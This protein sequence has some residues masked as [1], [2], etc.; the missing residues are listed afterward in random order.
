MLPKFFFSCHTPYF[1]AIF[2]SV[3]ARSEKF[4]FCLPMNFVC[5]A[6][7]SGE[8]PRIDVLIFVKSGRSSR[9]LHA[10]IVQ[11][12]VESFG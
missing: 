3:S 5:E 1:V 11:P 10:W 8:T 2:L 9:K 7:E 4:R 6:S 12:G